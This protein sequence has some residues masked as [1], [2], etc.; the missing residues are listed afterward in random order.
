MKVM[1]KKMSKSDFVYIF[2]DGLTGHYDV[3]RNLDDALYEALKAIRNLY[4]GHIPTE[5]FEK[6]CGSKEENDFFIYLMENLDELLDF[7]MSIECRKV[8]E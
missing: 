5:V 6:Y 8:R 1:V 4:D 2:T 7:D 3:Y